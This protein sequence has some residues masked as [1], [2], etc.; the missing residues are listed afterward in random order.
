MSIIFVK[1]EAIII[2]F[3]QYLANYFDVNKGESK[4]YLLILSTALVIVDIDDLFYNEDYN[5][6]HENYWNLIDLHN[7]SQLFDIR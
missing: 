1:S 7:T 4:L 2:V 5:C 3:F 6:L